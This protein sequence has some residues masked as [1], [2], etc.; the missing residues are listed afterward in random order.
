ME[1]SEFAKRR[2]ILIAGAA[3]PCLA[4]VPPGAS[5]Q[6][7]YPSKLIKLIVPFPAG[8]GA[9]TLARI[10][11]T[12][13]AG[14]FGQ[15]MVF[16]NLSG[17][18]GNLGTS[19]VARAE[20]DGYTLLYGTNGTL[21]INR[22]LYRQPGFDS[23]KDLQ[24]VS[25]LTHIGLVVVVR[26]GLPVSS[27][28]DLLKL[29]QGNPGKF[30]FSSSGN[31][32]TSHL[33]VELLKSQAGLAIVH[34]PYRG[35]APAITDL[36][37]GQVDMMV[38]VMPNALPHIKSGRLKALAVTTAARSPSLPEIPTVSE[39]GVPGF[40]VTAWDSIVVP[41]K[42]P[43]SVIGA[44]NKAIRAAL[45]DPNVAQK[46]AVRGA[47]PSATSPEELGAFIRSEIERWGAA[48]RRSG[49]VLE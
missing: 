6:G 3:A 9:D 4:L 42:T 18:G 22:T 49:A 16:E 25:R 17:A 27:F 5:A 45:A 13:A 32:T 34:I 33:A 10:I 36:I 41:A 48:V 46:I 44:V 37:G 31:G 15:P 12:R 1:A 29:L 14:E 24:P 38:E 28:A 23:L 19:T 20:P 30:T 7:S 35:G 8:G 26:P 11:M 43:A 40:V 47:M 39:S 2:A 21:A